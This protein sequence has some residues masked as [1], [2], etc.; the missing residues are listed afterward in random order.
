M[1]TSLA[2]VRATAS[3]ADIQGG[4]TSR[5]GA[6]SA[7]IVSGTMRPA[8]H[9]RTINATGRL[10][11]TC[12]TPMPASRAPASSN[13]ALV[14][15]S[16]LRRDFSR[17]H[18]PT[19]V[20]VV[21]EA[22]SYVRAMAP[23]LLSLRDIHLT[24]GGTALIERAD[25]IVAEGDRIALVGRNGSGKSTFMKIAAGIVEADRGDRS[26]RSGATWRYLEQD[27]VFTGFETLEDVVR[28]GLGPGDPD[29]LVQQTMEELQI[30][31]CRAP[32]GLSGGEA[33]RVA[34]ARALAPDPEILLLDEPTNHLD[35]PTI[36]WLERTLLARRG[37]LVVI[38]HDRRF[39]ENLTNKTVWLDRGETRELGQGF[40][41]FEEWRDEVFAEE[42]R[43]AHKLARKIVREEHWLRY[44]V[45]ARRKRNVRRL[46]ELNALREKKATLN[47]PQGS[48]SMNASEAESSGKKVI[49][50]RNLSFAYGDRPIVTDF[51]LRLLRGDRVGV[52]GPN[53][54]GKTTLL[55]LLTG[56]ID[57]QNGSVEH[58]TKLEIVTLDQQRAGL[59]EATRLV[60]AVTGGRGDMVS[61]GGEQRHAMSY[62]KDFLF[63]P[64]QAR[65]PISALS[66][67]ERGRLALAIAL[68]RPS[69]LLIL[70][71][72]TNDLDLETLDVLEE[73]LTAYQGTI[74]LVSHDR[75]FLDRI[76]TSVIAPVPD[77]GAGRWREYVGG[78]TEMVATQAAKTKPVVGSSPATTRPTDRSDDQKPTQ[79]RTAKLTYKE[80]YALEILPGRMA[81]LEAEI[82]Q[83][84]KTLA[85]PTLFMTDHA[86]FETATQGLAKAQAA[87]AAAEEEWLEIEMKREALEG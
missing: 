42:E 87:L 32:N 43:D 78:Y 1:K 74:I 49:D 12:P 10:F 18:I 34:L 17:G 61:V 79:A 75:D 14:S 48:V 53:G 44:G 13:I 23:P 72:P 47:R 3:S 4:K 6:S 16:K 45:T 25:L 52:A 63:T 67:G 54:A 64:D 27:P 21:E 65:Q 26:F 80:K 51:T 22:L 71:E 29:H 35:L 37:A 82:A 33:R 60:D 68:A 84:E 7:R 36:T 73:V 77:E 11:P 50:A 57:P 56:E 86:A 85:D 5:T 28:D 9:A 62:L 2:A 83:H 8:P 76:V 58:G 81:D 46:S 24:F 15:K 31:P 66:G 19:T 30:D 41:A 70:D 59:K 55:R 20:L 69:N 38:S 40:K 39:L